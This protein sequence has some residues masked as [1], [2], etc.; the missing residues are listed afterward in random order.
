MKE[1][2][3]KDIVERSDSRVNEVHV[4]HNVCDHQNLVDQKRIEINSDK[5]GDFRSEQIH[6]RALI[7]SCT[8]YHKVAV[9]EQVSVEIRDVTSD[10]VRNQN[11]DARRFV[12]HTD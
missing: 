5:K 8:D 9:K 10:K 11:S 2:V 4:C 7:N 3:I 12:D 1:G 6:H